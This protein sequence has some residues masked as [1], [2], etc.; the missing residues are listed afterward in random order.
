MNL[1]V[2]VVIEIVDDEL[3]GGRRNRIHLTV[4][5]AESHEDVSQ[6][7]AAHALAIGFLERALEVLRRHPVNSFE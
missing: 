7:L 5:I 1:T 4:W 3:P 6:Q 2:P